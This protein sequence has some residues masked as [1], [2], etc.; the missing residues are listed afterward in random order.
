MTIYLY[1]GFDS[2]KPLAI[3]CNLSRQKQMAEARKLS[4]QHGLIT[5]RDCLGGLRFEVRRD[6]AEPHKVKVTPYG[7]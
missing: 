6:A 2:A 1:A 3:L 4:R 7:R 5:A